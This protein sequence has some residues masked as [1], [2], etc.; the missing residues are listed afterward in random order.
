MK[1][2]EVLRGLEAVAGK[3]VSLELFK[4]V[5]NGTIRKFV[6]DNILTEFR[7]STGL[8]LWAC[9]NPDIISS[10]SSNLDH[11][12]KLAAM[13]LE[14]KLEHAW[15]QDRNVKWEDIIAHE[16]NTSDK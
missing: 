4:A 13:E 1:T 5:K 10:Y 11:A 7:S 3:D 14:V 8:V 15:E 6:Q 9:P 16:E 2:V 12:I